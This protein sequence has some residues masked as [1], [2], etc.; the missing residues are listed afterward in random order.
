[1]RINS[2]KNM[3]NIIEFFIDLSL[4]IVLYTNLSHRR[5]NFQ[6]DKRDN[7]Y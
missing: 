5:I 4:Y 2:Q 6:S 3:K 1:M 7:K